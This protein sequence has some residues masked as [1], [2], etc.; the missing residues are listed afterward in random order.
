MNF[1]RSM[2]LIA[3]LISLPV[4]AHA[5]V[6]TCT[7]NPEFNP[8]ITIDYNTG[9]N[10]FSLVDFMGSSTLDPAI[11]VSEFRASGGQL[12]FN[13]DEMYNGYVE[14]RLE[15]SFDFNT[16]EFWQTTYLFDEDGRVVGNMSIPEQGTCL[17]G[18][19]ATPSQPQAQTQPASAA[20]I[21]YSDGI[22]TN[23][24]SARTTCVSSVLDQV[25]EYTFGPESLFYSENIFAAAWCAGVPGNGIGESLRLNYQDS[26]GISFGSIG[27]KNGFTS[28]QSTFANYSRVKKLR[29]EID[30]GQSWEFELADTPES[31]ELIL[32]GHIQSENV[33][34]TILEVY[35][36]R[37]YDDVC[38][39]SASVFFEGF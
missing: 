4:L 33:Y 36:G 20:N 14:S 24:F 6:Y 28:D 35:P 27:I 12:H 7:Y 34:L 3:S 8:P 38:L 9:S 26:Q 17:I 30:S 22:Q 11:T 2:P 29:V 23:A 21:C 32:R 37:L 1:K 19:G 39:S 31:Q 18:G 16:Q 15:F 25:G 10:R 5:E 13:F